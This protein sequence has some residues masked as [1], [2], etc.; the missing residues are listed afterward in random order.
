MNE[1]IQSVVALK[2][3]LQSAQHKMSKER[4]MFFLYSICSVN[5]PIPGE[6]KQ[7]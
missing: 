4:H 2:V 7:W 1:Y 5:I 6:V 3:G